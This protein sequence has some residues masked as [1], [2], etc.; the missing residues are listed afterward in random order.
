MTTS[1][2]VSPSAPDTVDSSV[3]SA[4]PRPFT[5]RAFTARTTRPVAS[6]TCSRLT[7]ARNCSPIGPSLTWSFAFHASGPTTS[8]SSAPGMH[9]TTDGTSLR[10]RQAASRGAAT[11]K[12]FSRRIAQ[13]VIVVRSQPASSCLHGM[14]GSSWFVASLPSFSSTQ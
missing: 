3:A 2:R 7:S 10:S 14:D 5:S 6:S 8:T 12:L 9:G 1:T 13:L 11:E 4:L